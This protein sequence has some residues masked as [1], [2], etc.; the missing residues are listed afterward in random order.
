MRSELPWIAYKVALDERDKLT[1]VTEID[2]KDVVYT[3]EPKS[4][5]SRRFLSGLASILPIKG[6][7]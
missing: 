6:Q 7:L 4:S 5:F 3:K 1:W 2:G